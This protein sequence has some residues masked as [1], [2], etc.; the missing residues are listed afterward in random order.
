MKFD[1]TNYLES[2][3]KQ[4]A[5]YKSLGDR[6]I[7]SLS[8]PQLL[9][10]PNSHC[11][12]IAVIV[13]HLSGNMISRWTDFLNSDGEKEYRDR[14]SEFEDILHTTSEIIDAWEK[15]WR[16]LF[17]TLEELELSDLEKIVFIRNEG[18][19]VVEAINRQLSHYSYHVG[20]IVYLGV[21]CKGASWE[22]LSIPKNA[23]VD[24]N[25]GK[26]SKSK[27]ITHFTDNL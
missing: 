21:I 1:K 27:S 15:G 10:K 12:S 24:Y 8:E 3:E 9:F 19:T 26:F 17:L 14:D 18:H 16:C 20:Q 11:N 5:Y 7:G 4:F 13:N 6:T 2:I 22:S 25:E 23:S